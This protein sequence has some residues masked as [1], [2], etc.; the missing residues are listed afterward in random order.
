MRTVSEMQEIWQ[1][2]QSDTRR[3]GGT[4]TV[5]GLLMV[6]VKVAMGASVSQNPE[7]SCIAQEAVS[8]VLE[9]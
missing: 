3:G 2:I 9:T 5:I 6:T 1:G 4:T 7:S 8:R